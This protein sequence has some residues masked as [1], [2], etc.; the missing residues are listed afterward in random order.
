MNPRVCR[1]Y[2]VEKLPTVLLV[3]KDKTQ[4]RYIGDVKSSYVV[5]PMDKDQ[6]AHE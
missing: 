6:Q 2:K 1:Y 3:K 4:Y 5:W